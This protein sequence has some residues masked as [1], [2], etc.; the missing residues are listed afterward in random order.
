MPAR[1]ICEICL[2][3]NCISIYCLIKGQRRINEALDRN[4]EALDVV[5]RK[6]TELNM[7]RQEPPSNDHKI[8]EGIVLQ[9]SIDDAQRHQVSNMPAT[10]APN[11]PSNSAAGPSQG[12]TYG[13]DTTDE[14]DPLNHQQDWDTQSDYEPG[15]LT[16]EALLADAGPDEDEEDRA[17]TNA[18]KRLMDFKIMKRERRIR[19]AAYAKK[20][21]EIASIIGRF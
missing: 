1:T 2:E 16:L 11:R 14:P 9:E 4:D 20:H 19:E 21:Q 8:S 15:N 5:L 17:I 13:I 18:M 10:Q 3:A 6:L 7:T 12:R